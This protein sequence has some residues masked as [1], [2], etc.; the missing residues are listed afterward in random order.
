MDSK[1]FQMVD[2][3]EL[4]DRWFL[5]SSRSRVGKFWGA[6]GSFGPYLTGGKEVLTVLKIGYGW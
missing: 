5:G 2:D 4:P 1:Y 3:V 6:E